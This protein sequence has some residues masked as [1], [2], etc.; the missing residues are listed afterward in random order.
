MK[1]CFYIFPLILT[2]AFMLVVSVPQG[3]STLPQDHGS[4]SVYWRWAAKLVI[5]SAHAESLDKIQRDLDE[6][7]VQMDATL[8]KKRKHDIKKNFIYVFVAAVGGF[9]LFSVLG[10]VLRKKA[11]A[12]VQA[13]DSSKIPYRYRKSYERKKVP[14]EEWLSKIEADMNKDP[15]LRPYVAGLV[16]AVV[17]SVPA[18]LKLIGS[19]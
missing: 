11:L 13:Q 17:A 2:F 16:G 10:L 1:K 6:L 15:F 3:L 7:G 4:G 19:L 12:A 9:L 8:E 14:Q 18:I 5:P